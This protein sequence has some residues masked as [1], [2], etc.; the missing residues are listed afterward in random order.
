MRF[1]FPLSAF[2]AVALVAFA[3][4]PAAPPAADPVV[5]TIGEEKIT[6]SQFEAILEQ[7]SQPQPGQPKPVITPDSKRKL[8]ENLA[9]LKALAQEARKQKMDQAP[10]TK[11][12]LMLRTDQI[13]ASALFQQLNG[14]IAPDD[15]AKRAY[16]NDHKNDYDLVTARHILIRMKGSAVP[17]RNGGKDLTD[18][19]ALAKAKDLRAKIVAG[20]KFDE[21]AKAESDDTGSGMNG[22]DLGEFSRG[23]MVPP[24]EEAAFALKAGDVSEPVKTQFGYHVIQV[25]KHETK[26]FEDVQEEITEKVKPELAQKAIDEVKNKAT[27]T[28]D[29]TYF[30]R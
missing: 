3:Q 10:D 24:F 1:T 30:G 6:Q 28:F 26:K 23:R 11:L 25:Q 29:Q 8:A 7:A 13:L 4:Q 21:L 16:Y 19:E 17:L 9:E 15:A 12:Q 27:I 2:L 18:E 14:K 22:G 5:L 20:G